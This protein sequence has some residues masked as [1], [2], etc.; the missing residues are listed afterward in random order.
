MTDKWCRGCSSSKEP[1]CFSKHG[2]REDGLQDRCKLCEAEYYKANKE[3][4]KAQNRANHSKNKESINA[5]KRAKYA[6][7]EEYRLDRIYRS[8]S[9]AKDNPEKANE[10]TTRYRRRYPGRETARVRRRQ[11][12]KLQR[13]PFWADLDA[14]A[15]FY[16]GRPDGYEVDHI[17]PLRGKTVSGLHVLSN[18]QYLPVRVNR[19]KSN[20]HHA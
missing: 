10:R 3:R 16:D 4:K 19:R 20:K 15:S 18:L 5:A 2:G 14:I 17:I 12:A 11:M 1:S 6:E 7:D 8:V 9:W 13:T